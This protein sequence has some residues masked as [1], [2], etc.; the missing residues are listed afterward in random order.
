MSKK[1]QSRKEGQKGT[2][3]KKHRKCICERIVH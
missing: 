1:L 2:I 3:D